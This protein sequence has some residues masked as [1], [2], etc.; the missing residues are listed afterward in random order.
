MRID[1]SYAKKMPEEIEVVLDNERS[2]VIQIKARTDHKKRAEMKRQQEELRKRQ[3]ELKILRELF[4]K[5]IT[6]DMEEV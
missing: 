5:Y 3:A 2:L 1:L 4:E 6:Y